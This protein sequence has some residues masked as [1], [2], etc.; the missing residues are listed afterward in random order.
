MKKFVAK[1]VVA[2]VAVVAV[3]MLCPTGY[4]PAL[5]KKADSSAVQQIQPQRHL[6]VK[7]TVRAPARTIANP[8][9]VTNPR[10]GTVVRGGFRTV[11]II[12]TYQ[13]NATHANKNEFRVKVMKHSD[14]S[15]SVDLGTNHNFYIESGAYGRNWRVPDAFTAGRDYFV[16]VIHVPTGAT[17]HSVYFS[18]QNR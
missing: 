2:V 11:R 9:K 7:G 14:R 17:S 15:W 6:R 3:G 8:I 12:W 1:M 13:G 18:I 5:A 10:P 16:R 4:G